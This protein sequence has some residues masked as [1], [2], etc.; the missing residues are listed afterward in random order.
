MLMHAADIKQ[1]GDICHRG[2]FIKLSDL[3]H[4][5]AEPT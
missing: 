5:Y 3:A 1:N 4:Y 2:A